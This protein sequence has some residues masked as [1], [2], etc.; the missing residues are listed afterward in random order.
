MMYCSSICTVVMSCTKKYVPAVND[1][2]TNE[3]SQITLEV[4]V[5]RIGIPIF[6]LVKMSTSN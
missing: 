1:C 3:V 4:C 5:L 6:T 2:E